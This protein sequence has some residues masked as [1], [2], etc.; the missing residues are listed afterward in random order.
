MGEQKTLASIEDEI[1]RLQMQ[2]KDLNP[3]ATTMPVPNPENTPPS[4]LPHPIASASSGGKTFRSEGEDANSSFDFGDMNGKGREMEEEG[5][6][7]SAENVG[8]SMRAESGSGSVLRGSQSIMFES[9]DVEWKAKD[10]LII[11]VKKLQRWCK[12]RVI[13]V[14]RLLS[15]TLNLSDL[16]YYAPSKCWC[17]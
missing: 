14:H 9:G 2:L 7:G 10:R 11:F 1:K 8:R 5:E 15:Y 3:D 6:D 4:N 17:L 12:G 16:A 13:R